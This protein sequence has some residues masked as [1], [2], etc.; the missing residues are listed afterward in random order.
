[1]TQLEVTVA[2]MQRGW[3]GQEVR[4]RDPK[5]CTSSPAAMP[6]ANFN[7]DD[8][9]GLRRSYRR[10]LRFAEQAAHPRHIPPEASAGHTS[11]L[12]CLRHQHAHP[13]PRGVASQVWTVGGAF[14]AGRL[15]EKYFADPVLLQDCVHLFH[16]GGVHAVVHGEIVFDRKLRQPSACGHTRQVVGARGFFAHNVLASLERF[17]WRTVSWTSWG[18]STPDALHVRIVQHFS[19]Q[20]ANTRRTLAA[21][22]R[23][24]AS[25]RFTS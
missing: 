2:T 14:E 23:S 1:M 24:R 15:G 20:L 4:W 5:T 3:N 9:H 6:L 8:G 19:S 16:R 10:L 21:S 12:H 13:P 25:C 17:N 18:S 22:A 11:D 7:K